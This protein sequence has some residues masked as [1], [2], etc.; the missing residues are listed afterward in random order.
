[1]DT[2]PNGEPSEQPAAEQ[3]TQPA[4]EQ[5]QSS[6]TASQFDGLSQEQL[7]EVLESAAGETP[8]Q[9]EAPATPAAEATPEEMEPAV[10]PEATPEGEDT[11]ATP[12]A[13]TEG[14]QP[15]KPTK[16][17]LSVRSLPPEQ[18]SQLAQA[19]EMVRDGKAA[20]ITSALAQ[21]T[22]KPVTAAPAAPPSTEA[23][24]AED[25]PEQEAPAAEAPGTVADIQA[26]I[27]EL[28]EQRRQTI[29][30]FDREAEAELTDQIEDLQLELVRAEQ[31]AQ[32]RQGEAL[33]YNASYA[34]AVKVVQGK[35]EAAKD[36]DSAFNRILDDKVAAAQARKDPEL[37]DPNFI[38]RYADEVAEMLGLNKGTPPPPP[39]TRPAKPVGSFAPGHSTAGRLS[40]E[41]ASKL[42][43]EA[44]I[45][46]LQKAAFTH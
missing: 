19:L 14:T 11:D 5:P 13:E 42:I 40:Q 31:T 17:R 21:V 43:Q 6:D 20:D 44:S 26:R 22:G 12:D 36:D 4:G 15:T 37:A 30:D 16:S 27:K 38:T 23:P 25:A 8:R 2:L 39:P 45:E 34:E 41:A 29:K 3:V 35:Y 28:R 46:D 1:M 32:V 33:T 24:T 18:Q 9:P 10:E 7:F